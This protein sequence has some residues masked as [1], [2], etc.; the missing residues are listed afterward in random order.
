MECQGVILL[1][2][3]LLAVTLSLSACALGP[4]RPPT[5][6]RE[7]RWQDV[8]DPRPDLLVVLR[9]L[10]LRQD[11]G[12][13]PL[14]E[15]IVEIGRQQSRV[16]ADTRALEAMED[17]EEVIVSV[18]ASGL[19][20][21]A[22]ASD[23]LVVVRGVR[24]DLDPSRLVDS[25]GHPLWTQGPGGP[26]REFVRAHNDE[27]APV[28]VSLFELPAR[29]WVIAAGLAR[30]RARH[31]IVHPLGRPAPFQYSEALAI[32]RID[33]PA[34]VS[35]L[36]AL[37]RYGQLGLIGRG[38]LEVELALPPNP[39][40]TIDVTLTYAN[41]SDADEAESAAR[42][43][44]RVVAAAGPLPAGWISTLGSARVER[45]SDKSVAIVSPWPSV[46]IDNALRKGAGTLPSSPRAAQDAGNEPPDAGPSL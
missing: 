8:I 40:R 35:R 46:L 10:A 25:D 42:T 16:V 21:A 3:P 2:A 18:R 13:G 43:V 37:R 5:S 17:A 30:A 4:E 9:P 33:G 20:A 44:I 15:R 14:L 31:A 27:A 29:T 1:R 39:G 11:P 19:D 45:R 38:L 23:E 12:V 22:S 36:P 41:V 26:V 28:D 24:A 7:P 32:V 6:S 34:L